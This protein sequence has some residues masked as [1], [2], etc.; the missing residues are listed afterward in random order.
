MTASCDNRREASYAI[1]AW[2]RVTDGPRDSL[3]AKHLA[4]GIV[5]SRQTFVEQLD[6]L[7][8]HAQ[9]LSLHEAVQ[10]CGERR[11]RPRTVVLTFD[12]GFLEHFGAVEAELARR[13]LP[14][15]LF[16]CETSL[17]NSSPMRWLEW[18]Y[19]VEAEAERRRQRLEG[20]RDRLRCMSRVARGAAL[21]VL[22]K[23]F[24]L[25]PR[26]LAAHR[27]VL[28]AG[29]SAL[30]KACGSGLMDIG[31]HSLSHPL[32]S[33]LPPGE[34]EA[35]IT[36]SRE[37]LRQVSP[38]ASA[39][40][41]PFGGRNSYDDI[42]INYV[43]QA[44]FLCACTSRPGYNSLSLSNFELRRFD[45]NRFTIDQVLGGMS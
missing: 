42:T 12:D 7:Q 38:L 11:L 25:D 43:Q 29:P 22:S 20:L 6:E 14:S 34:Q 21:A 3:Y 5:T 30:R 10:R 8:K 33:C 19:L 23:R 4:A 27:E 15:T 16:V 45:M 35:E 26:S 17:S 13:R 32:L 39:F 9:V 2:H 41:F 28:F 37:L 40:A 31:G 44:G 36:G 24:G 18:L 1:L